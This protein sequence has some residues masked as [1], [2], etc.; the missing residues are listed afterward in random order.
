MLDTMLQKYSEG[1]IFSA[2]WHFIPVLVV[3]NVSK[4]CIVFI[5]R[6]K[7]PFNLKMKT[8]RSCKLQPLYSPQHTPSHLRV[9]F[10]ILLFKQFL[11]LLPLPVLHQR[12]LLLEHFLYLRHL[13]FLAVLLYP[14]FTGFSSTLLAQKKSINICYSV[15]ATGSGESIQWFTPLR[16]DNIFCRISDAFSI[17]I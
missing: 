5:F 1:V 2:M 4:D 11:L 3:P 8:V 17:G 12:I 15:R 10:L 13:L 9:H 6:G 7:S 16:Q 14:I